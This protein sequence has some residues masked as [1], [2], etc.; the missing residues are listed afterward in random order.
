LETRGQLPDSE[1]IYRKK[2]E[3]KGKVQFIDLT[4]AQQKPWLDLW[5]RYG[6]LGVKD[7]GPDAIEMWNEC[8]DFKKELGIE[9]FPKIE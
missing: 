4:P 3:E 6:M 5:L 2:I 9:P 1:A 7:L 8:Q